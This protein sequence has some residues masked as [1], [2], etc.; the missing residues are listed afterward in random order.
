LT[1]VGRMG[2]LQIGCPLELRLIADCSGGRETEHK[3]HML[4][5]RSHHRGEWFKRGK[6]VDAVLE[7][8]RR[9]AWREQHPIIDQSKHKRFGKALDYSKQCIAEK[10]SLEPKRVEVAPR[11]K[12]SSRRVRD[13]KTGDPTDGFSLEAWWKERTNR[14]SSAQQRTAPSTNNR[15]NESQTE[16][17]A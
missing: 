9:D 2:D 13:G 12:P 17:S 1:V 16:V 3:I 6:D 5:F 15:E 8:M 4:L 10:R 7:F 11:A 14:V